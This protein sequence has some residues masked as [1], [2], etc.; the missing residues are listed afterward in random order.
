VKIVFLNPSG[1][2]GG[3]ETALLEMIAAV[4]EV[5]PGWAMALVSSAR[6]PLIARATQAGIQALP[7]AFPPSLA[8]LGEW[9]RG[10]SLIGRARLAA[11]MSAAALP[12]LTYVSHLRR[13]L[14]EL[15]PDIVHTN[16]LKM[17]LL[18]ARARPEAARLIWHMHD[19]PDSKRMTAALLSMHASRCTAVIANSDSVANRTRRF[20]GPAVP[21]HTVHNAV[22][23]E[24][25]QP[26]GQRVDLD[27]LANL[28]PLPS[29]GIRIGLIATFARWKGHDVFLEALAKLQTTE[30]VR[31]YVVGGPIYA[32][33][34]SQYTLP[35]LR[36]FAAA[37][38]LRDAVG[39]TGPV[40]DIPAVMRSL[41]IVVHASIEPEP[42][43]LVIAEAMA[44][45]RPL[46]VSRA[47]GA[48][49]VAEA[50]ALFHTPGNSR[51]LAARLAQLVN[52]PALRAHLGSAGRDA[53][54][55]LFGHQRLR[56]TLIPLY[57]AVA[58]VH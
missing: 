27:A 6:G 47:G 8:R 57:E 42:F 25:F 17:H 58:R 53:A 18:G 50:G 40:D 19:Y 9:G 3:A 51:E 16:G 41:D 37:R 48:V 56:D 34:A 52:D 13:Y 54:E 35:E 15:A 36:R 43:G 12:T 11:E 45:G 55:R 5:R 20:L 2:L 39:F 44:C 1:E 23:L 32:T 46:V 10:Q 22:D 7:F 38:G 29:G 30:S 28:P 21:V 31:G 4:R 14:A 49:E 26:E 24:R 33:S